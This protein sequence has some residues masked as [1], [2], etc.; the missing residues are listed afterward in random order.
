MFGIADKEPQVPSAVQGTGCPNAITLLTFLLTFP[1][2]LNCDLSG[3]AD[4]LLL[5]P[6]PVVFQ[7]THRQDKDS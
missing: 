2:S 6:L 3:A 1:C 5:H 7:G 4:L